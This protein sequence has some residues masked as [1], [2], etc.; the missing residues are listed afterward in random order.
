M[1]K[2][3]R[4]KINRFLAVLVGIALLMTSFLSIYIVNHN[5]VRAADTVTVYF[6]TSNTGTGS[7]YG[8][9]KSMTQV[10]YYAYN[11]SGNNGGLKPMTYAEESGKDGG[12][13]FYATFDKK[14]TDI[15]FCSASSFPSG[16]D[17]LKQTY[18]LSVQNN[19]I[20]ILNGSQYND[21]NIKYQN[22]YR[23]GIY[24]EKTETDYAGQKYKLCNM[25]D[26]AVDLKLIYTNGTDSTTANVTVLARATGDEVTIP[27]AGDNKTPYQ[28]VT[29]QRANGSQDLKTYVFSEGKIIGQ[30]FYYGVTE[31]LPEN[32]LDY[33]DTKTLCYRG[34]DFTST[35]A[36]NSK[37]LYFSKQHFQ[38]GSTVSVMIGSTTY[39]T[40]EVTSK[41]NAS[42]VTTT[43][44]SVAANQIFSVIYNGVTY[45]LVWSDASKNLVTI[46]G[47]VAYLNSVYTVQSTDN[48]FNGQK[49]ITIQADFFDYQY[50]KFQYLYNNGT[51]NSQTG[52]A[53]RPY[54]AVNT[55]LSKSSYGNTSYPLY[56]GQF[57]LPLVNESGQNFPTS[58]KAYTA[59]TAANQRVGHNGDKDTYWIEGEQDSGYYKNFGFGEKMNNFHWAANLA[60]RTSDQAAGTYRPYDAVVQGLVHDTLAV[61]EDGSYHLM[62]TST[63]TFPYFDASWWQGNVS[64]TMKYSNSWSQTQTVNKSDYLTE[65]QQLPFPFFEIQDSDISFQNGYSSDCML[66]NE[67]DKYEGT[68][69][70]FDSHKYSIFVDNSGLAITGNKGDHLVYDNY[71]DGKFTDSQPG[72]FPFNT[73]VDN[74]SARLHYGFGVQY[75][76][77]FFYNEN[78]TLNGE[79]DGIPITFTF[80]GDDDVWVFVDDKLVLDMGGAHKNAIGE[81]N[82][83]TQSVYIGSAE[84]ITN[85]NKDNVTTNDPKPS[86]TANFSNLG[87]GNMKVGK[88]KITMYYLER[89]M[90][91]SNLYVMFNL[92]LALTTW[93]LQ[94]D[95]D[96][97][98]VN[99]G[100]LASTK[101]VSDND[102]FNYSVS[103]KGTE[104][105]GVTGSGY[106]SPS[107]GTVARNNNGIDGGNTRQTAL[108]EGTVPT[109]S[110]ITSTQTKPNRIYLDT[111]SFTGWE[112]GNA[113]YGAFM[114]NSSTG[115]RMYAPA[116]KD[117]DNNKWYVDYYDAYPD[118]IQWMRAKPDGYLEDVVYKIDEDKITTSGTGKIWGFMT[119]WDWGSEHNMP[120]L[121]QKN[122][123]KIT[124]WKNSEVS[125]T[126]TSYQKS[127]VNYAQ[128]YHTY[129]FKP[130]AD[131]TVESPL[132]SENGG[133]TYRLTDMFTGQTVNFDTRALGG[134][135]NV[136]S[137]Q[138]GEWATF[139]KQFKKGSIMKVTQ[140][141]NLS[142]PSGG[143]RVNTYNEST[144]RT[145][146]TYYNTFTRSNGD[147]IGLNQYYAGIYDGDD[148]RD[149]DA[150]YAKTMYDSVENYGLSSTVNLQTTSTS[151]RTKTTSTSANVTTTYAF[152]DPSEV[153]NEYAYVRQVIVNQVKTYSLTIN[154]YMVNN[155]RPE[156]EFEFHITFDTIFGNTDG[157]DLLDIANISYSKYQ[158]DSENNEWFETTGLKLGKVNDTTGSFKLKAKDYI[159]ISGIPVGTK[160]SITEESSEKYT[161]YDDACINL[162]GTMSEDMV[163]TAYNKIKTGNVEITKYVY[164][165][166]DG[167]DDTNTTEEFDIEFKLTSIP[168]GIDIKQYEI[169]YSISDGAFGTIADDAD[170][171]I[172]TLSDLANRDAITYTL[173]NQQT[174]TIAGLPYGCEYEVREAQKD[175]QHYYC[176]VE[177]KQYTV[178]GETV[179]S[180]NTINDQIIGGTEEHPEYAKP[181]VDRVWVENYPVILDVEKEVVIESAEVNQEIYN[182]LDSDKVANL[183]FELT[184]AETS[185]DADVSRDV[186]IPASNKSYTN[187]SGPNNAEVAGSTDANGKF[188]I[189]NDYNLNKT[190]KTGK[191]EIDTFRNQF[192]YQEGQVKM[193]KL[194][195]KED[196]AFTTTIYNWDNTAQETVYLVSEK[197]TLTRNCS[198]KVQNK[199]KTAPLTIT[200]TLTAA[201]E[202]DVTFKFDVTLTNVAGHDL[203]TPQ[204]I[205]ITK[206]VTVK[207]GSTEASLEIDK[208][209][210]NTTYRIEEVDLP[211]GYVQVTPSDDLT[212][213]ITADGITETVENKKHVK[214]DMPETG[215][216]AKVFDFT[217]IGII[218]MSLAGVAVLIYKKKLKKASV[219][220]DG[221]GR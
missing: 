31:N 177:P 133:V 168:D 76:M 199:L 116:K 32:T 165:E 159:V 153:S 18:H 66:S 197:M 80:Q 208:I 64:A 112:G 89:G 125:S 130:D 203:G 28:Q 30:T 83:N 131:A 9:S 169:T 94:E 173:K 59:A 58:D 185:Y 172:T 72:F 27:S 103:N 124:D 16:N 55:A 122:T 181:P 189:K 178:D 221:K 25:T 148:L 93:E 91:N 136:V 62:A 71:G 202:E 85:S 101:F 1:I 216:A 118:K 26:T 44:V 128:Y 166:N 65:Y 41:G 67:N 100:F 29:V 218:V 51:H 98:G 4:K 127:E 7:G 10:Y 99:E 126:L 17:K 38:E 39:P 180:D 50:D 175:D 45:N 13:L 21:G 160:Y 88:H 36:V 77:D 132:V 188:T 170:H 179:T 109:L 123:I 11:S 53:K 205:V 110:T 135:A 191:P 60:Y 121:T 105:K 198:F 73:T 3:S 40:N 35:P 140:L 114:K 174:L 194:T 2:L 134:Q 12:K 211:E 186:D 209:P 217:V 19:G 192:D 182:Q 97:E 115:K 15:I 150:N 46:T 37:K 111:S 193:L 87:V 171:N 68:Y 201:A 78:G 79:P 33:G 8:W 96:F 70:V 43:E 34:D 219:D 157:D 42:Y 155:D 143:S 156:D 117:L 104:Q 195:E 22:M 90:L 106:K 139:S 176:S 5:R 190:R 52:S 196:T 220:K 210:V 92:P 204:P 213:T 164:D 24:E 86:Y 120:N 149:I 184:L 69:Y 146:S 81:I 57:W 107:Y 63:E 20:Y 23:Y 158:Y 161:L 74:N 61:N 56:L 47:N 144:G 48:M 206:S 215:V 151:A 162:S 54:V 200:K 142:G 214:V 152:V 183:E 167:I 6:D 207:A 154:K 14:Y 187:H 163:A 138:H 49:Y 119:I 75:T 129:N 84:K 95:T 113:K 212:G 137:L 145:V 147:N 108:S 102:I 141:D 82:F